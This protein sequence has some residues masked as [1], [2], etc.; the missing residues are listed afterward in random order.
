MKVAFVIFNKGTDTYGVRLLTSILRKEGHD[1]SLNFPF[2]LGDYQEELF[3]A[4][5]ENKV[6]KLIDLIDG[7]DIV[8]FSLLI[9]LNR[10]TITPKQLKR[11]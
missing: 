1:V 2:E 10:H 5:D 3:Q 7:S 9:T 4:V 11:N 6:S 8:L